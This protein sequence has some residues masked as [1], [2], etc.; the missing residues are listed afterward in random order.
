MLIYPAFCRDRMVGE[1]GNLLYYY[2]A[3][4]CVAVEDSDSIIGV[5]M[6]LVN[7]HLVGWFAPQLWEN[8]FYKLW[9]CCASKAKFAR[10]LLIR[11]KA[12]LPT[13]GKSNLLKHPP[14]I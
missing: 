11:Q 9:S 1:L 14:F 13:S 2:L 10:P 5:D 8:M 6:K 4:H 7:S 12:L 3:F